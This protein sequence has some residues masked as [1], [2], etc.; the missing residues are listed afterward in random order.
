L[1]IRHRQDKKIE[2]E[3]YV[4]LRFGVGLGPEL[5]NGNYHFEL[6]WIMP[7]TTS[8]AVEVDPQGQIVYAMDAATLMYRSFRLPDLYAK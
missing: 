6:G 1:A 4:D 5:P 2:F 3:E 8:R 7:G